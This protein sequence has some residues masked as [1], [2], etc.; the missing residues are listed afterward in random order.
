MS[1][2]VFS[3]MAATIVFLAY[4]LITRP[5]TEN[6]GPIGI[7]ILTEEERKQIVESRA[8]GELSRIVSSID[9]QD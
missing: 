8:K 3:A 7:I 4:K 2:L 1:G 5:E 6:P 9:K